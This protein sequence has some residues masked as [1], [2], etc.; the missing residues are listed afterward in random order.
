MRGRFNGLFQMLV[1]FGTI[2]GQL[3]AGAVGDTLPI[4]WVIAASMAV[5]LLSVFV[6]LLPN[7]EHVKK[8]YNVNA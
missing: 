6:I 8:I 3:I 4:R 2:I 1:I 5:T 7:R